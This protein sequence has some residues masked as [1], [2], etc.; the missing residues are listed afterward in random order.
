[1]SDSPQRSIP[2][3]LQPSSLFTSPATYTTVAKVDAYNLSLFEKQQQGA[4]GRQESIKQYLKAWNSDWDK[5]DDSKADTTGLTH[6]PL[7]VIEHS[8]HYRHFE[9]LTG[10]WISIVQ[11]CCTA[12][13]LFDRAVL[14]KDIKTSHQALL[15]PKHCDEA[16]LGVTE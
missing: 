6:R 8:S 11:G 14:S 10:S 2:R 9:A 7:N 3:E 16:G 1:M 15:D 4:K 5:K 13:E 12:D